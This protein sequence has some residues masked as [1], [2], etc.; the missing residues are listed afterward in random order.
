MFQVVPHLEQW[1]WAQY[2]D[3]IRSKLDTIDP[4]YSEEALNYTFAHSL[5]S[6]SIVHMQYMCNILYLFV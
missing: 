4:K 2:S 5:V 6:P 3:Y 1:N